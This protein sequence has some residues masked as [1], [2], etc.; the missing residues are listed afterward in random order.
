[1]GLKSIFCMYKSLFP[2]LFVKEVMF[3]PH[4]CLYYV[5]C[6]HFCPVLCH[7][8]QLI[9]FRKLYSLLGIVT[10]HGCAVSVQYK[11][12]SMLYYHPHCLIHLINCP[13][14]DSFFLLLFFFGDTEVCIQGFHA[15]LHF[16]IF[17]SFYFETGSHQV[18]MLTRLYL[19]L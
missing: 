6:L 19:N 5:R 14:F 4:S 17:F 18:N 16:Q 1:M 13:S 12:V 3:P 10:V 7:L 15:E 11:C 9:G 2:A 8:C